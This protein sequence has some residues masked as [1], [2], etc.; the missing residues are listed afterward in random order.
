MCGNLSL[1]NEFEIENKYVYVVYVKNRLITVYAKVFDSFQSHP[2]VP[3]LFFITK[4]K[5]APGDEVGYF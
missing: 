2:Q 4:A 3:F 1:R 5:R